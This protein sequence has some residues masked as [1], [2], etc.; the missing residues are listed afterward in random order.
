MNSR[1]VLFAVF[2]AGVIFGCMVA[3]TGGGPESTAQAAPG[4]QDPSQV[5]IART[6][7]GPVDNR[8]A[9]YPGTETLGDDEI[10]ITAAGT[11]MPSARRSQAATCFVVEL[12]NGVSEDDL[13]HHDETDPYLAFTLAQL[14]YPEFP[15]PMGVIYRNQDRDSYD[16][17]VHDQIRQAVDK[18]GEGDLHALLQ[19][20]ETWMIDD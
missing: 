12:G 16:S 18:Q 14:S 4:P 6:A 2:G 17:M 8:Y 10:R 20:G 9:Y 5:S 7:N 13:I 3:T 1:Y 19:E 11:G 15:E